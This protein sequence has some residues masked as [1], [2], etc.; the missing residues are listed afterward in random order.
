[1]SLLLPSL[2]SR[3]LL[4]GSDF[5]LLPSHIGL[6]TTRGRHHTHSSSN[7]NPN[8]ICIICSHIFCANNMPG[9]TRVENGLVLIRQSP[10]GVSKQKCFVCN[11]KH[12]L[13]VSCIHPGCQQYFHPLCGEKSG[14]GYVRTRL[15]VITAFCGE[16]LPD[17]IERTPGTHSAH[18]FYDYAL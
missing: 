11:R 3:L 8:P 15:G 6:I 4:Y 14:R 16:H 9:G 10:K 18:A 13:C 17:G 7:P 1:M 2:L 5:H 12:G